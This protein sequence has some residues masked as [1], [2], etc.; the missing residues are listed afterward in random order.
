MRFYAT[1]TPNSSVISEVTYEAGVVTVLFK[2]GSSYT[3]NVGRKRAYDR[4]VRAN[5]TGRYYNTVFKKYYGP[6]DIV[7]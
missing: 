2:S 5:S 6:G 7:L 4:F 3:Y 1:K